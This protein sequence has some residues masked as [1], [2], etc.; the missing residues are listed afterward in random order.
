M[1]KI[2]LFILLLCSP[3]LANATDY[4]VDFTGG[5][6]SNAGTSKGAAWKNVSKVE[7]T[8]FSA[9]DNIYFK[10]GERWDISSTFDI[11]SSGTDGTLVTLTGFDTANNWTDEGDNVWSMLWSSGYP[12]ELTLDG[13]AYEEAY[14]I[15]TKTVPLAQ[16][17][18]T[19]T[20]TGIDSTKRWKWYP[21]DY[22]GSA[23]RLY[24]YAT[25]NPATFYSTMQYRDNSGH[26]TFGAYGTGAKPIIDCIT[27][28]SGAMTTGN[29]TETSGGS[30]VWY[31]TYASNPTRVTLSGTEYPSAE[32]VSHADH[33]VNST[34]RWYRSSGE[35]RLYVYSVGNPA[36]T[37]S[38]IQGLV[39]CGSV[40]YANDDDNNIITGLDVRG[41][42]TA[43]IQLR[44]AKNTIIDSNTSGY[45]GYGVI[46]IGG[47][48]PT[49]NENENIIIR[50]NE[51][52]HKQNFADGVGYDDISGVKEAVAI[53]DSCKNCKVY[54]NTVSGFDHGYF[55][56]ETVS[57]VV[58]FDG[59]FNLSVY[60]NTASS[61]TNYDGRQFSTL[62]KSGHLHDVEIF[63]NTFFDTFTQ[64]KLD[65]GPNVH[66]HH[67]IFRN[68]INPDYVTGTLDVSG[69]IV[70]I[71]LD[72]G[73]DSNGNI[74]EHNVFA[75]NE[76]A[77]IR[78]DQQSSGSCTKYDHVIQN[79]IVF[80]TGTD[81]ISA[82]YTDITLDIEQ[83]SNVDANT[84]RN[85]LIYTAGKTS[86]DDLIRYNNTKMTIAEFNAENGDDGNAIS[87]NIFGDPL[88]VD[89]PAY[90]FRV[91]SASPARAAATGTV[92][93]QDWYG[94]RYG[95]VTD[96]GI[97]QS[98]GSIEFAGVSLKGI[99]T[100]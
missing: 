5:D 32:G 17:G 42:Q 18:G 94:V 85:N 71:C 30:N 45:G 39:D 20:L 53:R 84:W 12:R 9:G 66:V 23:H 15:K 28:I 63:Y 14:R 78:M 64:S 61:T 100:T 68:A 24:V 27:T 60:S 44:G 86:G 92:S 75:T 81:A 3:T 2:L 73:Y 52:D 21:T 40:I 67:N 91:S 25:S 83:G 35:S 13:V 29:W 90:D 31:M 96:I 77:A 74:L 1:R 55:H 88:F 54:G 93:F 69:F 41:G 26:I 98:A 65:G 47:S 6:D 11:P 50:Q 8:S 79:N 19:K 49:Y 59:I 95:S 58:N 43:A 10:R 70:F 4:Y 80:N 33:P 87:D 38:D 36:S 72:S 16:T 97:E 82:S 7:G 56:F 22:S 99:S 37:Y 76:S 34:Y 48:S 89:A 57:D 62:G 51:L 46:V